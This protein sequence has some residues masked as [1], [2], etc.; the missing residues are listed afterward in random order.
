MSDTEEKKL[1]VKSK[2]YSELTHYQES[3]LKKRKADDADKKR[4]LN[5]RA[6]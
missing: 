4:R 2:P 1:E 5:A 3:L 6:Q